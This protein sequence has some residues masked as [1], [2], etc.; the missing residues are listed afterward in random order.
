MTQKR[1]REREIERGNDLLTRESQNYFFPSLCFLSHRKQ[2]S[3][4]RHWILEKRCTDCEIC[5]ETFDLGD[6]TILTPEEIL[7]YRQAFEVQQRI[8]VARFDESEGESRFAGRSLR[9]FLVRHERLSRWINAC[10]LFTFSVIMLLVI[11]FLVYNWNT[12]YKNR[13]NVVLVNEVQPFESGIEVFTGFCDARS[14]MMCIVPRDT[15]KNSTSLQKRLCNDPFDEGKACLRYSTYSI[16]KSC[17]TE[18]AT[19]SL[20]LLPGKFRSR[21]GGGENCKTF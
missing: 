6:E 9:A 20:M 19:C 5:G 12:Y 3:C 4:L 10:I 2:F 14:R 21:S 18:N 1:E 13:E 7:A 8:H 17:S 15:L 11:V 16:H